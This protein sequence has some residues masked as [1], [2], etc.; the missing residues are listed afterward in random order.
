[1]FLENVLVQEEGRGPEGESF[2]PKLKFPGVPLLKFIVEGPTQPDDATLQPGDEV[3]PNTPILKEEIVATRRWEFG[4]RRGAWVINERFFD[5]NRP[6]ARPRLGSAERWIFKNEGGGWWHPI[7]IHLEAF[8]I[9]RIN[10]KRPPP[11]F[12]GKK[13]TILLG[14]NDEVEVFAKFRDYRGRYVMHCHNVEHEDMRMMVRF[15]VV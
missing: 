14:P 10:G 15:D 12:S 3:Q 9:Q 1:V 5:P 13:D 8:Q 11:E 7:H 6:D 2:R 4:R